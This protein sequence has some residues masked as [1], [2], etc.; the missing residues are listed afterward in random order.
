MIKGKNNIQ[1][2][3]VKGIVLNDEF[4]DREQFKKA[5]KRLLEDPSKMEMFNKKLIGIERLTH[6]LQ[7]KNGKVYTTSEFTDNLQYIQDEFTKLA[8]PGLGGNISLLTS[9]NFGEK[10]Q[11]TFLLG[12]ESDLY[13]SETFSGERVYYN[14]LKNISDLVQKGKSLELTNNALNSHLKGFEQ[15]LKQKNLQSK[16]DRYELYTWARKNLRNRYRV[17]AK[18]QHPVSLGYYFWGNNNFTGYVQESFGLHLALRHPDILMGKHVANLKRSVINEHGGPGSTELFELLAASK[19]NTS[20]QLSGDIVV[21]DRRGQVRFN[22]QSKASTKSSYDFTITYQQFL[23]NV[24][25]YKDIFEKFK[26]NMMS[27]QDV[28]LLFNKFST[29]AWQPIKKQAEKNIN[30]TINNIAKKLIE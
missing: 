23:K 29:T 9:F 13:H 15:N 3:P 19:G 10:D 11:R 1:Y 2:Q 8:L 22:I 4:L 18:Q 16:Q 28:D 25:L 21:I 26:N 7:G 6:I 12:K 5:F 27:D 17:V 14:S 24:M 30:K 20:S